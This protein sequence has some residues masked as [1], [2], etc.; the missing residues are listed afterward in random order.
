MKKK[1]FV[2]G[3]ILAASIFGILQLS[4][5][6]D[7]IHLL[8]FS[9]SKGDMGLQCT[10][11]HDMHFGNPAPFLLR[12]DSCT[13]CHSPDGAHDGINDPD[14]G[15]LV[16]SNWPINNGG[17]SAIFDA[18]GQLKPGKEN[19]CLGCHDDGTST[20]QGIDAPNIA[21]KTVTGDWQSPETYIDTG[22]ASAA[23]LIDGD[24]FTGNADGE[25][26]DLIFDLGS[27]Q[28]VTHLRI[29]N[30]GPTKSPFEVYGS[31]DLT[32]WKKILYGR[33]VISARPYWRVVGRGWSETKLDDFSPVRYIK[34]VRFSTRALGDRGLREFEYR[35]NISYG[36]TSTGH[37]INCDYCHD[38]A[39]MHID[40]TAQTY[41]FASNN[42]TEGYRL[43]DLVVD[44]VTVPALEVP[45]VDCNDKESTKASND[46]A[47]CVTCHDKYNLLG[48]AY[49]TGDYLKDPLQ[50]FFRNDSKTDENGNVVN[51]HIR[52][53]RGKGPCGNANSWDSD[54][55]GVADSPQSCTACHNVH[56]S[57]NPAMTRHGELASTP[58][59]TDK[60]PMLNF[61]YLGADGKADPELMDRS[62]STG[63]VT[64]YYEGGPGTVEKNKTCKMCHGDSQTF[65]RMP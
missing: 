64:Q 9:G 40:S 62:L 60:V 29:Y 16:E 28:D 8:H 5:A 54:W 58:G 47:L 53:L 18:N 10:D 59:T 48:D 43:A 46:F 36:Y 65:I 2:S 38:T 51:M 17:L 15:V 52:H 35:S 32:N 61:A 1:L 6:S 12:L 24:T 20:V 30:N 42:Y 26:A 19:W 21:G 31:N 25:T 49:G 41:S 63:G 27:S 39:S 56:G 34:L 50:T 14:I 23:S 57:P 7:L 13:P 45:R 33:T 4:L 55:D 3:A 37:N 22:F 11:C 44:S